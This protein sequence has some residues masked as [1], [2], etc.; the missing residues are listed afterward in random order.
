MDLR[1]ATRQGTPDF[2]GEQG[3]DR[4]D[5]TDGDRDAQPSSSFGTVAPL[6]TFRD[7]STGE[8]WYYDGDAWKPQ[9]TAADKIIA[10]LKAA[11]EKQQ[12][13]EE[14]LLQLLTQVRDALHKIASGA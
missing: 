4:T 3:R 1:F 9:V 2:I 10:A 12:E 13:R 8:E 5:N 6:S 7:L 14:R 11:E